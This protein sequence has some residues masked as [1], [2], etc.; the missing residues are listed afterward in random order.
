MAQ[1]LQGARWRKSRYSAD[2]G[3]CIE[4]A[5]NLPGLRAVRDSKNRAAPALVVSPDEWAAFLSGVKRGEI[6]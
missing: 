4:V 2:Q 5:S 3:E 1:N 6:G